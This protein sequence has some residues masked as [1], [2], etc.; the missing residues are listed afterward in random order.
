MKHFCIRSIMGK[1]SFFDI[2]TIIKTLATVVNR[3]SPESGEF[4]LTKPL[5]RSTLESKRH[6]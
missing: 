6:K 1:P 3:K 4:P 2:V 5:V